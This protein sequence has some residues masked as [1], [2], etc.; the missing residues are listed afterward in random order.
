MIDIFSQKRVAI[1]RGIFDDPFKGTVVTFDEVRWRY[2]SSCELLVTEEC[3]QT[4][5]AHA[6]QFECHRRKSETS[7]ALAWKLNPRGP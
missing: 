1:G 4:R 3:V 5:K 7:F 2:N 6:E